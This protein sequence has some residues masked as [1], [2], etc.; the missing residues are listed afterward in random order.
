MQL[1]LHLT[2]ACNLR[3]SYC[4]FKDFPAPRMTR[5]VALA[6]TERALDEGSRH[7]GV[8]FFGGEPLLARDLIRDIVPEIEARCTGRGVSV[9]FKIPTN[10]TLLDEDFVRFCDRRAVFLSLSIDGDEDAHAARIGADGRSSFASARRALEILAASSTA[11]ATYSVVTPENAAQVARSVEYLHSAGSRILITA[12]DHA[13]A[14]TPADLRALA[15]SYRR[16]SKFYMRETLARRPFYLSTF[17]SKINAHVH[18]QPDEDT[19]CRAGVNQISVAPDGT[20][21]PCVQF[22]ER[23]ELAIGHVSAVILRVADPCAVQVNQHARLT[24]FGSAP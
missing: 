4:Y 14:W 15:V 18:P 3:C 9:N 23:P 17:D 19:A 16:L 5:E 2:K 12:L 7:L 13:A 22:V 21:F 10:G 11:F 6:A 8:T 24:G 20:L 1:T